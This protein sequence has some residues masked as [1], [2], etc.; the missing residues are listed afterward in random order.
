MNEKC[1]KIL[2]IFI[3]N[4]KVKSLK[5]CEIASAIAPV[6]LLVCAVKFVNLLAR[7][8]HLF[9]IVAVATPTNVDS[10]ILSYPAPLSLLQFR[11]K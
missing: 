7:R 10:N 8:Q 2:N 6:G 4:L 9:A 11:Q 1:R 5:L 3:C